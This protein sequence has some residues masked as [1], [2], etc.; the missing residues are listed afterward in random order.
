MAATTVLVQGIE[1]VRIL[2]VVETEPYLRVLASRSTRT[3]DTTGQRSPHARGPGLFEKVVDLNPNLPDDA[4]VA[5]MNEHE[6]GSLADL[7]GHVL[8]TELAQRQ[9]LLE[10]LDANTRLQRLS[11]LLGQELTY[12]TGKPHP[13]SGC[14]RRL[15]NRTG[16]LSARANA[17]HPDRAR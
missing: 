8:D 13:D 2:E 4:Y 15:T 11:I 5:A 7:V 14:S 9:E 17:R 1:R 12:W 16:V 3:S 6:P 10:T